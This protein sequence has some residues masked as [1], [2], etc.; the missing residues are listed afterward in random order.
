MPKKRFVD[1]DKLINAIQEKL[2]AK[3]IMRMFDIKTAAQLKAMYYE[4][5]A[6]KGQVASIAGRTKKERKASQTEDRNLTVNKRGSLIIPRDIIVDL[7]FNLDDAFTVRKT[8]VGLSLK[9]V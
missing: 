6:E 7:G 9:K 4:A 8:K 2:T 3:E 1:A 5:L